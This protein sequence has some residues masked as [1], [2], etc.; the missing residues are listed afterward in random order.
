MGEK[1]DQFTPVD[2]GMEVFHVVRLC[3][4]N[5][6]ANQISHALDHHSTGFHAGAA[7]GF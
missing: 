2:F 1:R 3:A 5:K 7:F 6:R 4:S